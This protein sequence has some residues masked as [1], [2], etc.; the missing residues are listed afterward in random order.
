MY[1]HLTYWYTVSFLF[2]LG[3]CSECGSFSLSFTKGF[4][5]SSGPVFLCLPALTRLEHR[6]SGNE[7]MISNVP[8]RF[9]QTRH[10]PTTHG[11]QFLHNNSY[12]FL[13]LSLWPEVSHM[14]LTTITWILEALIATA[15]P[16]HGRIILVYRHTFLLQASPLG[17]LV[18]KSIQ[19]TRSYRQHQCH[20]QY[21][22]LQCM[23][24][25]TSPFC[26][27]KPSSEGGQ[28]RPWLTQLYHSLLFRSIYSNGAARCNQIF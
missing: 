17:Q 25:S 26:Y 3:H 19:S 4:C 11:H 13:T 15:P 12:L 16:A 28:N 1:S 8:L 24:K 27:H 7:P 20:I 23:L 10:K 6:A 14:R 2:C 22:E 21:T 18:R 5:S 9:L